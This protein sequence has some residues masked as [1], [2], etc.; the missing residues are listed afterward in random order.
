MRY[1]F[2][3]ALILFQGLMHAQPFIKVFSQG[4]ALFQFNA[5]GAY[6]D[7]GWVAAGLVRDDSDF[8]SL[9]SRFDA[10]GNL[11]W[12]KRPEYFRS[13]NAIVTLDNGD[14]LLF[15]NNTGLNGYFDASVLHLDGNGNFKNEIVWGTPN[16]QDDWLDARKTPDG[17][18]IA[19]GYSRLETDI[20]FR[21]MVARFSPTGQVLWE[22]MYDAPELL[23]FNKV[24]PLPTGGFF[25]LGDTYDFMNR[26]ILI[27]RCADDGS[28]L[29]SRE[30]GRTTLDESIIDGIHLGNDEIMVST[31]LSDTI[32]GGTTALLR[33]DGSGAITGQTL[34]S[35]AQGMAPIG[36]GLI[37]NDTVALAAL[38]TP[39]LFP[40]VDG[41]LILATF[42]KDGDLAGGLAFGSD[43]QDFGLDVI[44]RDGEA[45]FCGL[46]DSSLTGIA[47]RAIISKANPRFS[48]CRKSVQLDILP[49]S[50]IPVAV[51]YP[52]TL[53]QNTVKTVLTISMSDVQLAETV[54]CQSFEETDILPADTAICIGN[55][56]ELQP[57]FSVPGV[58]QWSTGANTPAIFVDTPGEY[59]LTLNSEC[60]LFTDTIQVS[61]KGTLPDITVSPDTAICAGTN[62]ILSASGGNSY[63][64]QDGAG[65][66]LS[67]NTALVAAPDSAVV[68]SVIV[69]IGDCS[70]TA[71]V[72]VTVL[73]PP[74]V[75]A[76]P[77]TLV[78][79]GTVLNLNASG[80]ESYVW[81]PATGLSCTA[82]PDPVLIADET[83]VYVVTGYDVNGCSDADSLQIDVKKP[84]PFY[85]PN[86]FAP[87]NALGLDNDRFLIYGS[88]IR[89]QGFLLRI[90]SR[91]GELVFQSED[92]SAYWDGQAGDREAAPGVYTYYLEMNTCNGLVRKSGDITLIR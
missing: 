20:I 64:W 86:I 13:P 59:A 74:I 51:D 29:W 47:Q 19:V 12:T 41:D 81:T 37:G 28:I 39:I 17:G 54:S 4:D 53:T 30:Y 16:D 25:L 14:L 50:D 82:C 72:A 15:N 49:P 42:T 45:I 85:I 3:L 44:F 60:G 87:G 1:L 36:L 32:I 35:N 71:S 46:T 69:S 11:L 76:A 2:T 8:Y 78:P 27:V 57:E 70:D 65:A 5:L 62:A 33:L 40:P 77:D 61:A 24:V 63:A 91:W 89:P 23:V 38:S 34:I 68:Y 90:Y 83:A 75:T 43:K 73:S 79:Q 58:Y 31:Y 80:A 92:A 67:S 10:S 56:F 66:V 22:K 84:C 48:C 88:D 55:G 6:P 18:A 52:L 21:V 7:K 26:G 9:I